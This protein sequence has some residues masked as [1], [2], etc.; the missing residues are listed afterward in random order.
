MCGICGYFSLSGRPE[1][2]G[3]LARM[4][5]GLHHRGPDALG[6]HLAAGAALACRRLSLVD[7]AGGNQP[8]TDE[9]GTIAMVCN[10]EVFNHRELRRDLESRGH[11]FRSGC[12]V[13]VIVHLYEEH[14]IRMVD[15]LDG[16]FAIAIHDERTQ[17]GYLVRDHFGICPMFYARSGERLL[18]ASEIKSIL[19][20]GSVPR[21]L[22]LSGLDQVLTLP[23]L[24]SPRTMF[25]GIASLA[26]GH[27][28]RVRDGLVTVEPYWDL[29]Y[30]AES[31]ATDS[32]P[33]EW[34][35]E[36][37]LDVLGD[38]VERRADA[39]VPVGARI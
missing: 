25:A 35:Q 12:D 6:T 21:V 4:S 39:D 13:E 28:C 29:D 15:R 5:D 2:E 17:T 30:P 23:G 20:D 19:A 33:P 34:Y 36:H 1:P 7:L 9:S 10:G 16:Q 26:P 24:V 22:D 38:A 31:D 11:R 18:F 8:F 3:L 14:G 37:L 32:H 27:V